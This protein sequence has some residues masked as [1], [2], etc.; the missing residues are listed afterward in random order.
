MLF[1]SAPDFTPQELLKVA[2]RGRCTRV[3]LTFRKGL[4]K[5]CRYS[6]RSMGLTGGVGTSGDRY[7]EI[8][9]RIHQDLNF[10]CE[11]IFKNILSKTDR[12]ILILLIIR[13]QPE[14]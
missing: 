13:F 9:D 14:L 4:V 6:C 8:P 2:L 7:W 5:P 11:G 1:D 3:N 10:L 12:V